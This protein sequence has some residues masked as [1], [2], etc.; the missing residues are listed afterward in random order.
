MN[1]K[2]QFLLLIFF[3]LLVVL[4]TDSFFAL[5]QKAELNLATAVPTTTPRVVR[6]T[7]WLSV[8]T[9]IQRAAHRI[10]YMAPKS[11]RVYAQGVRGA[12]SF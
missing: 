9:A 6:G 10:G 12:R 11:I 2:A 1:R 7:A 3:L 4:G 5:G 8:Y